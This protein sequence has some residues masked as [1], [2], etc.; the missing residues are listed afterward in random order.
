MNQEFFSKQRKL[1]LLYGLIAGLAFAV[2]CWGIDMVALARANNSFPWVKFLPGLVFCLILCG[3]VGW[4]T[5]FTENHWV[6][7]ISWLGAA[8]LLSWLT[9]WLQVSSTPFLLRLLSPGLLN[10]LEYVIINQQFQYWLVGFMVIGLAALICGLLEINLVK[11][12]LLSASGISKVA[13]MLLSLVLFSVVGS[14]LDY[15]VNIHFRT[16][17]VVLDQLIEFAYDN[18]DVE[19][20]IKIAREKRLSAVKGLEDLIE[21]KRD[22]TLIAY[23]RDLGQMDILVDFSGVWVRCT[24]IY[25]Q[26]VFCKRISSIPGIIDV[27][28]TGKPI[29]Y[30][31]AWEQ[32]PD[33]HNESETFVISN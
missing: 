11:A 9:V 16:P 32:P 15:M 14:S 17:V 19:V 31:W 30:P 24:V 28:E 26:P 1:G 6:A 7:L 3:L 33:M 29:N 10:Y 12:A 5:I 22:L 2:F 27:N 4:L 8:A 23:D 25:N 20:P 13:P 21:R 18:R